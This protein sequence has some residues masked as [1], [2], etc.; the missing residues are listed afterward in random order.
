MDVSGTAL[1]KFVKATPTTKKYVLLPQESKH[2]LQIRTWTELK[3]IPYADAF[4]NEE[5][6]QLFSLPLRSTITN[7]PTEHSSHRLAYRVSSQ[8]VF[9]KS[10]AFFKSKIENGS[11]EKGIESYKNWTEWALIK[12]AEYRAEHP[13]PVVMK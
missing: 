13:V 7:Q 11:L 1:S 12:I 8:V 2:A 5:C 6:Y 3:N 4:N 9:R 10:V